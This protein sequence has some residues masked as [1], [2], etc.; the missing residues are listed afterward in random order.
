MK[1]GAILINTARGAVVDE[2]AL[3]DALASGQIANAGLD[4]FEHEPKIHPGLLENPKV[5]LL[6]HMGTWTAETMAAMEEWAIDNIRLA[7][8]EGK[9][10]SPVPEQKDL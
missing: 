9:L 8:M 10:K 5:T 1:K 7:V 2:A 6:P 3:V 4:V